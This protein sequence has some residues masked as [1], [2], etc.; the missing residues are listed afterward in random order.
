MSQYINV[1]LRFIWMIDIKQQALNG[2]LLFL[3]ARFIFLNVANVFKCG[4]TVC[5]KSSNNVNIIAPRVR[6]TNA[7][8]KHKCCT[9]L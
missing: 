3:G 6:T 7:K 4:V 9:E 2:L 5:I 8:V 1:S